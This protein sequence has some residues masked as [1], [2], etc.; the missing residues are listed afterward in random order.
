[1]KKC[2]LHVIAKHETRNQDQTVYSAVI[3]HF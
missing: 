2:T 3:Q 1:M